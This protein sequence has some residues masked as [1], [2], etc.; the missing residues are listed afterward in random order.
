M[1]DGSDLTVLYYREILPVQKMVELKT[2]RP[3]SGAG[4]RC[5]SVAIS[6]FWRFAKIS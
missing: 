4:V 6:L 2:R 1:A 5:I 3:G